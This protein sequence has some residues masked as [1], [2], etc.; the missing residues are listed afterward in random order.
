MVGNLCSWILFCFLDRFLMC[1][2]ADTIGL[3]SSATVVSF[4]FL[5]I[6]CK[7]GKFCCCPCILK[8]LWHGWRLLLLG[9]MLNLWKKDKISIVCQPHI[10]K[11]KKRGHRQR[12][13]ACI[14]EGV[15]CGSL[16]CDDI[17]CAQEFPFEWIDCERVD[18]LTHISN[19]T[20]SEHIEK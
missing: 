4:L 10:I 20:H 7:V 6:Q 5:G 11:I 9:H 19:W 14:F 8:C 15:L 16:L 13:E 1:M 3:S 2:K 18:N 12:M 17:F